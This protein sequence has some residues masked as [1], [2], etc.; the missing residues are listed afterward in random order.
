MH[1]ILEEIFTVYFLLWFSSDPTSRK[2]TTP[3]RSGN[4]RFVP[5]GVRS[6]LDDRF[7]HIAACVNWGSISHLEK[8]R[9]EKKLKYE[10]TKNK[11]LKKK[12]TR[13]NAGIS[14]LVSKREINET[15][16]S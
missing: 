12:K 5:E 13:K 2:Q 14:W 10:E 7:V 9:E 1:K 8:S 3:T 4:F 11:F 16:I 15:P 6:H